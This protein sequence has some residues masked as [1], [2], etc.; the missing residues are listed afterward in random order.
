ME[1][2]PTVYLT[3]VYFLLLPS[4]TLSSIL[5]SSSLPP[6]SLFLPASSLPPSSPLPL[7]SL[8]PLS[9]LLLSPPSLHPP[10]LIPYEQVVQQLAEDT[11]D[12]HCG[13][14]HDGSRFVCGEIAQAAFVTIKVHH[15]TAGH[16][17]IT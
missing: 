8:P 14:G 7:P 5:P 1:V 3:K 6:S 10:E 12:T 4:P 16:M 13:L 11:V 17:S 2:S 15:V 9:S